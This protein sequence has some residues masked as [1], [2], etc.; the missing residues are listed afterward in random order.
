M[1]RAAAPRS[2]THHGAG[3]GRT[4]RDPLSRALYSCTACDVGEASG[5]GVRVVL[6]EGLRGSRRDA[7]YGAGK[8]EYEGTA[9][10]DFDGTVEE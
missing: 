2:R 3:Q 8:E 9:S 7:T 1:E 6:G 4:G 10:G 5:M